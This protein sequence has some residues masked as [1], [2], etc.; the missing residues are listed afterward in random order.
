M[1]DPS[2]NNSQPLAPAQDSATAAPASPALAVQMQ[3]RP[4]VQPQA[5]SVTVGGPETAPANTGAVEQ[6]AVPEYGYDRI[7][8]IENDAKKAELAIERKDNMQ[9]QVPQQPATPQQ[10]LIPKPAAPQGPKFFG[11]KV[12]SAL[13]NNFRYIA[14]QKG[15]GDT[16]SSKT[17]IVML[18]DRL[19]KKQTLNG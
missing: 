5:Q 3:P 18:L 14:S 7:K 19:L 10:P 4:A 6:Q 2:M 12:S 1:N 11:Y 8:Q 9:V 13:A 16:E 15:K 17:W